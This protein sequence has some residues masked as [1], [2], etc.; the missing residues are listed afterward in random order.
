MIKLSKCSDHDLMLAFA[1]P[2]KEVEVIIPLLA[3]CA[4]DPAS[5]LDG[6]YAAAKN[7]LSARS[8]RH[9]RR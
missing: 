8:R 6:Y 7:F 9:A 1:A 5:S 3:S 4:K 2:W